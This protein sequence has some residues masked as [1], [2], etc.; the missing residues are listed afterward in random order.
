M[1]PRRA[2]RQPWSMTPSR[3]TTRQRVHPQAR[4]CLTTIPRPAHADLVLGTVADRPRVRYAVVAT[5][6]ARAAVARGLL[7][8]AE[9]PLR[10]AKE[11]L[12]RPGPLSSDL[13]T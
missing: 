3:M 13:R 9:D 4:A 2:D 1:A 8:P 7:G 11:V 5:T 6:R 10:E 12:G